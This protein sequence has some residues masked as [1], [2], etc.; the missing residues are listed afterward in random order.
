M[1]NNKEMLS[2]RTELIVAGAVGLYV[3]FF[4]RPAPP[5]VAQL[6]SSTVGQ[7]AALAAVIYVGATQSL[8]V[9]VVLA[10]ALVLSSPAREHLENAPGSASQT[11]TVTQAREES[12]AKSEGKDATMPSKPAP[13]TAPPAPAT[14]TKTKEK[15]DVPSDPMEKK[16][17]MGD[18]AVAAAGQDIPAIA[19]EKKGSESFSLMNAAPF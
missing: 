5:M 3:V 17:N 6:L 2:K 11:N 18:A 13:S 12:K 10:L 8:I 4:T 14:T 1:F 9:A 16:M 19:P 15:F 7:I